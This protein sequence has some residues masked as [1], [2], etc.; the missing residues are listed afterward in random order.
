LS[1]L[2]GMQKILANITNQLSTY[3]FFD[4]Q[5]FK[6]K[7]MDNMSVRIAIS[8]FKPLLDE[9]YDIFAVKDK[10]KKCA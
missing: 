10:A 5:S 3:P 1:A 9:V 8:Y 4:N 7:Y 2:D 6:E